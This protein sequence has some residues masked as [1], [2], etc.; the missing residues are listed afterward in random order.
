MDEFKLYVEQVQKGFAALQKIPE[1]AYEYNPRNLI[2]EFKGAK[3]FQYKAK[4][5]QRIKTPLLIIFA[6]INRVEILDLIPSQSFIYH[7]L[8]QGVD[9]FL[10]DWNEAQKYQEEIYFNNYLTDYIEH[11]SEQV[12]TKTRQKEINLLGICQGGVMSLCYASMSSKIKNLILLTTPI[13]FHTTPD[14][15]SKMIRLSKIA[16]IIPKRQKIP[17]QWL[18]QFFVSLRPFDLLGR[19]YLNFVKDIDHAGKTELFLRVEKWLHDA[20]DQNYYAMLDFINIFYVQNNFFMDK[21][22]VRNNYFDLSQIQIPTLNV[23]AEK[24]EIVPASASAALS[25]VIGA[26]DYTETRVSGG[27]IGIYINE[28]S[29]S[30]LARM[31]AEWL[32]VRDRTQ[33]KSD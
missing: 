1:I 10:L 5:Q 22:L 30:V 27:H 25:R 17:G 2:A 20:P 13:D 9:V 6:T 3:L 7:L 29:A 12:T 19:K 11:F 21:F 8:Q 31:I 33:A 15:V 32:Y 14:I 23:I 28:S 26:S 4:T 18:T 16:E 24:D